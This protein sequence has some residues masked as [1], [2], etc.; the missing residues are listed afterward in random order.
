MSKRTFPIAIF[1]TFGLLQLDRPQSTYSCFILSC[2]HVLSSSCSQGGTSS[3]HSDITWKAVK[4]ELLEV[5]LCAITTWSIF[6]LKQVFDLNHI[7]WN[8][9]ARSDQNLATLSVSIT[10]AETIS[11][12]FQALKIY[13]ESIQVLKTV[14][15]NARVCVPLLEIHTLQV[16][17]WGL[18]V[19]ALLF[20]FQTVTYFT[21]GHSY[22]TRP[23]GSLTHIKISR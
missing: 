16:E 4:Q 2:T 6:Q 7:L 12:W 22:G 11:L 10:T 14:T 18:K 21:N 15:G 1:T 5:F 20:L 9:K 13:L 23:K 8:W 17:T 19:W 3:Q